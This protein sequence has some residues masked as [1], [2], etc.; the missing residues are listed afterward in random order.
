MVPTNRCLRTT[1]QTRP[2]LG[3]PR[4]A[5]A[6]VI[7]NL[8]QCL[9]KKGLNEFDKVRETL[10]LQILAKNSRHRTSYNTG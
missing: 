7:G 4:I 8:Q 3:L 5:P 2:D 10:E 1:F 6:L 9:G